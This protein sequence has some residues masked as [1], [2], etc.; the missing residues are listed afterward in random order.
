MPAAS[1]LTG[2]PGAAR[3]PVGNEVPWELDRPLT[4]GPTR[5]PSSQRV[6]MAAW[7]PPAYTSKRR[8]AWCARI[9]HARGQLRS[10]KVRDGGWRRLRTDPGTR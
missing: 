5:H 10:D 9:D 2:I 7:P 3:V 8:V 4:G 6:E 1:A